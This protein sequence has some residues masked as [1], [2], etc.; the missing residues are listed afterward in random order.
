MTPSCLVA[1]AS[2]V[3]VEQPRTGIIFINVLLPPTSSDL[4]LGCF[5]RTT[6]LRMVRALGIEIP[7]VDLPE[8]GWDVDVDAHRTVIAWVER[9]FILDVGLGAGRITS[10]PSHAPSPSF[11]LIAPVAHQNSLSSTSST[12]TSSESQ[13][14]QT[15]PSIPRLSLMKGVILL[16]SASSGWRSSTPQ[17]KQLHHLIVA[18]TIS[19]SRRGQECGRPTA[20]VPHPKARDRRTTP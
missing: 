19:R 2:A 10:H 15:T 7:T 13:F 8:H 16:S 1:V 17:P 3:A 4:L 18:T 11:C 5:N 12:I 14:S 6:N 9:S 20:C